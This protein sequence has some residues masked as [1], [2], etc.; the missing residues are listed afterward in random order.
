MKN[1]ISKKIDNLKKD[2]V[3]LENIIKT[4]QTKAQ[5]LGLEIKELNI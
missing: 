5:N 3:N 4:S 2:M 1:S